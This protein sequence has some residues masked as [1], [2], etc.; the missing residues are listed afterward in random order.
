MEQSDPRQRLFE[1]TLNPDEMA[2]ITHTAIAGKG[3]LQ[4][5]QRKL[6]DQ[7]AQGD[8]VR[9]D[10]VGL[11][12]LIRYISQYR[13]GGFQRRLRNAFERSLRELLGF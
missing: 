10:N 8:V 13:D 11:G 9:F 6:R 7:L 4:T 12:Q 5:L 1:F 2:F 3:G